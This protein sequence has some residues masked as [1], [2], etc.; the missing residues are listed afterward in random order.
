MNQKQIIINDNYSALDALF[1]GKKTFL[2]CDSSY[3]FLKIG[4]HFDKLIESGFEIIKFSDFTPNP[5]YIS[6]KEAVKLYK[7]NGCDTILAIGGGSAMDLAKCVKLYANMS[8]KEEYINQQ[9]IPNDIPLYAVPTTAGTG[10]EAT[11]YAVIY[12]N[13]NKQSIA[14]LSCIPSVVV[15]D[16]SVLKTLPEYQRKATMMDAFCHSIESFWSVNS[17]DESKELSKQAISLILDNMDAYLANDDEGNKNM[18][19]AANTAGKAIN[20]TQTTAGHAMCYK[21]TSLYGIA[22]G[23]AAA[24]CVNALLPYMTANTQNCIDSRGE[25][26]LK[27]VFLQIADALHCD[28]TD[29]LCE[30]F[31]SIVSKLGLSSPEYKEEDFEILKNSVNPTRLKNNP[32]SLS[33][34]TIDMLYHQILR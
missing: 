5:D 20:I 34:D 33:V 4:E 27:G 3:G 2:V 23:H 17:T 32:V 18:L 10:S 29:E 19:K 12:Y 11:R 16:S 22:H 13:G 31:S 28:S 8:D 6:V 25:E 7:E 26:Y 30:K 24:L 14:D 9:I 21:L 15:F 1:S